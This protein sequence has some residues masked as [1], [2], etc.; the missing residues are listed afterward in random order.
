MIIKI[1]CK[2]VDATQVSLTDEWI[3]NKGRR[4]GKLLFNRYW[5]FS[6]AR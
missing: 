3:N 6:F 1:D 4:K 5:R 2:I